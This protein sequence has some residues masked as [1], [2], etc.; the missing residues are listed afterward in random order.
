MRLPY[1]LSYNAMFMLKDGKRPVSRAIQEAAEVDIPEVPDSEAPIAARWFE[2]TQADPAGRKQLHVRTFQG[3]CYE[4]C[5]QASIGSSDI[6]EVV[7]K[8]SGEGGKPGKIPADDTIA[9]R[10]GDD[11]DRAL[12]RS[13]ERL[14][15]LLLVDGVPHVRCARPGLRLTVK[16]M[17]RL[18]IVRKPLTPVSTQYGLGI[19]QT[20]IAPLTN[21]EAVSRRAAAS[22]IRFVPSVFDIDVLI[23]EA[24]GFD[25]KAEAIVRTVGQAIGDN[26]VM[27][28]TWPREVAQEFIAIRDDYRLWFENPDAVDIGALLDRAYSLVT[29]HYG[30]YNQTLVASFL[31]N[32]EKAQEYATALEVSVN[33]M[34]S[35]RVKGTQRP[36]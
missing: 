23:P 25:A 35:P 2:G 33:P 3:E 34:S 28:H 32:Y 20:L 4:A 26:E 15:R 30:L 6:R 16:D 12:K 36:D 13:E 17:A 22:P 10:L 8:L 14:G 18:D 24:V 7:R 29:G 21:F 9:H 11:R 31:S 1:L 5:T 19:D 27:L